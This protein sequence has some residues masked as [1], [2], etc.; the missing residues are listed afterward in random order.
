MYFILSLIRTHAAINE[1][2]FKLLKNFNEFIMERN[3]FF[4]SLLYK[5]ELMSS[6]KNLK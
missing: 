6:T 2:D 5:L 3:F 1:S 4:L